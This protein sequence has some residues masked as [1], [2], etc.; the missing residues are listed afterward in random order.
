[1]TPKQL[2]YKSVYDQCIA[3]GCGELHSRD[4]ATMA[5]KEFERGSHY[6]S[7]SELIKNSVASAKK[8]KQ[9]KASTSWK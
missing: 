9:R 5:A 1:M 4:A 7:A 2:V 3:I 8:I 6:K